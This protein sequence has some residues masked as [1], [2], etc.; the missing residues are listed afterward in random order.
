[1][2]REASAEILYAAFP[3]TPDLSRREKGKKRSQLSAK[4]RWSVARKIFNDVSRTT[5]VPS[6]WGEG[7]G[8]EDSTFVH[9]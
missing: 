5:T 1:M 2:H 3:L 9:D 8:E 4:P 6:P 7:Q